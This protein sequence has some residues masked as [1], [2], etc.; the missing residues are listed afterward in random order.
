MKYFSVDISGK[1]H[2]YADNRSPINGSYHTKQ[3]RK[4]GSL[5]VHILKHPAIPQG[6]YT[7]PAS[8]KDEEWTYGPWCLM[9]DVPINYP[10]TPTTH[11]KFSSQAG[12]PVPQEIARAID[13]LLE[14]VDINTRLY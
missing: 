11:P 7:K 8:L 3:E 14:Q 5:N 2:N 13:S 10:W 6:H 1:T 9:V 4:R 12:D